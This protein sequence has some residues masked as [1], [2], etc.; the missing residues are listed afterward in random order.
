[1]ENKTW[2]YAQN[3]IVEFSAEFRAVC[4]RFE[5]GDEIAHTLALRIAYLHIQ[6]HLK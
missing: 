2:R 1:M 4:V 6:N 3:V 5:N